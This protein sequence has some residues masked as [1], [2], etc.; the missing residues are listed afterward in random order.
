MLVLVPLLT[1]G[2]GAGVYADADA[3]DTYMTGDFV[4]IDINNDAINKAISLA[5]V[6]IKTDTNANA[7]PDAGSGADTDFGV[8]AGNDLRP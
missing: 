4:G 6:N 2:V 5:G 3:G 7:H 8:G 1:P